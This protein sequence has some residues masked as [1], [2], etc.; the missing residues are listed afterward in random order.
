MQIKM[1]IKSMWLEMLLLY[2][3]DLKLE[4]KSFQ[5]GLH[6]SNHYLN[7]SHNLY[8][9]LDVICFFLIPVFVS[10]RELQRAL[11]TRT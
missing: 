5:N 11:F 9:K 1:P 7:K 2:V 3:Q 8:I 4:F 6:K 10:Q